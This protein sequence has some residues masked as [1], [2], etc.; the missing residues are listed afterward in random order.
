[1]GTYLVTVTVLVGVTFVMA[2][3]GWFVVTSAVVVW[4]GSVVVDVIGFLINF[5][6]SMSSSNHRREP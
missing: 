1:M 2:V 6:V 3:L 4:A 5:L